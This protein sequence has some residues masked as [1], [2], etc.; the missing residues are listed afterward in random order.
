MQGNSG[1]CHLV[2][3]TDEPGEIT[4]GESLIKINSCENCLVQ[5]L[6]RKLLGYLRQLY[7]TRIFR[8]KILMNIFFDSQFN[9]CL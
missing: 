5:K 7:L 1:R 8:K 3:S 4:V 2:L 9:C 6:I